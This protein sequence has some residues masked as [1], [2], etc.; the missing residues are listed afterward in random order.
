VADD[1]GGLTIIDVSKP[2]D[3]VVVG[4]NRLFTAANLSISA[5]KLFIAG[6]SD[7]LV[8][9]NLFQENGI[10]LKL[11][12]ISDRSNEFFHFRVQGLVGVSGRIERAT[13]FGDW[14][15]WKPVILGDEPT[16]FVDPDSET[17]SHFYRFV[18]P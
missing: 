15:T 3:P 12:T 9:L 17:E 18:A 2:T 7:G 1:S 10:E 4:G 14:A 13:Q 5:D 6:G 11:Q 8:I 16:D